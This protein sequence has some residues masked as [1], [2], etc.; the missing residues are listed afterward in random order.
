MTFS[1]FQEPCYRSKST[2]STEVSPARTFLLQEAERAW[3]ESEAAYFLRSSGSSARY[4][5]TT[6]S[7]R[8]FQQL[9]FEEQSELLANFAASGMTVDGEFFPLK[10]WERI[11]DAIDG[12]F[13]PT[14]NVGGGG[15]PPE[16]LRREGNHFVRPSGKKAHLGLDHWGLN[17]RTQ[18]RGM[19]QRKRSPL[20]LL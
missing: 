13:W 16:I 6:S 4:D 15:N 5:P 9:L 2:S 14:P 20:P 1:L 11:T 17:E 7:W 12:G 19:E 10:M 8:T 18:S 3:T